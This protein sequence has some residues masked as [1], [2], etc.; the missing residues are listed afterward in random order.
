MVYEARHA[1]SIASALQALLLLSGASVPAN[2]R[3]ALVAAHAEHD[4]VAL[5]PGEL[6][7][8]G[9]WEC[10]TTH[11]AQVHTESNSLPTN[12]VVWDVWPR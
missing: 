9:L 7:R 2:N 5:F 12:V 1:A 11:R 6:E 8:V 10:T 4:G 3:R